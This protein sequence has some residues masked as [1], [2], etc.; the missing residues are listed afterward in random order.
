M[1]DLVTF[2]SA[3]MVNTDTLDRDKPMLVELLLRK[4]RDTFPGAELVGE[5]RFELGEVWAK[6][7]TDSYDEEDGVWHRAIPDNL[8]PYRLQI[9][10]RQP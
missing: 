8:A 10:V 7:G 1:S 3:G 4:A 2:A 5:A 9:D 6:G